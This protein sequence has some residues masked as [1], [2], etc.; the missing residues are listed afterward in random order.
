MSNAKMYLNVCGLFW[1]KGNFSFRLNRNFC[2]PLEL[3]G[4]TGIRGLAHN[5]RLSAIIFL[6]RLNGRTNLFVKQKRLIFLSSCNNQ[7]CIISFLAQNVLYTFIPLSISEPLVRVDSMNV[8]FATLTSLIVLEEFTRVCV[9]C[10][11]SW[12]CFLVCRK[13]IFNGRCYIWKFVGSGQYYLIW[14]M[15]Y[16]ILW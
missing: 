4:R 6:T 12:S 14:E 7:K 8:S 9:A 2:H 15:I 13:I 11:F 5:K 1:S 16:S 10:S 3:H